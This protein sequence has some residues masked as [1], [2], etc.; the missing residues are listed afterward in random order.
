V[1]TWL[2][3]H[4]GGSERIDALDEQVAALETGAAGDLTNASAY[5]RRVEGL[6]YGTDPRK[7]YFEGVTFLHPELGFELRLPAMWQRRNTA[8]SLLAA[9][10]AGDAAMQLTV[11]PQSTLMAAATALLNQPGI[12][13]EG[14]AGTRING[15]SALVSRLSA[16]AQGGGVVEA[17]ATHIEHDG[18]IF[19]I[20]VYAPSNAF[21]SY[22]TTAE[23]IAASFAQV[24]DPEVLNVRAPRLHIVDLDQSM[25]LLEF[26]RRFPSVV[27]IDE[28]ALV[29]QVPGPDSR[30]A[31]G[32]QAKQI[33]G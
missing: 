30:L 4:P 10:P 19:R 24:D 27:P 17:L 12:R 9:S 29:N 14:T 23:N 26:S 31:S 18:L 11:A 16:D 20:I 13:D 5:L 6:A 25:S 28:V 1:P 21:A 8:S 7:G 32:Q 33:T 15:N 22:L 3:T 2:A